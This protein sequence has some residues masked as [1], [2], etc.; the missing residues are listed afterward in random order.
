[1]LDPF[2]L[3]PHGVGTIFGEDGDDRLARLIALPLM[4][5]PVLP[6]G[7][8]NLP[9]RD[10]MKF[11]LPFYAQLPAQFHFRR[12]DFERLAGDGAGLLHEGSVAKNCHGE[13]CRTMTI[14]MPSFDRAQDDIFAQYT[15][16]K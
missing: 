16:F 13:H 6:E 7:S 5:R 9:A 15:S 8:E 10:G 4:Q 2:I 1:M 12:T 11:R 14:V 3:V